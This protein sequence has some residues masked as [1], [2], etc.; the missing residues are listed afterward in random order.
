MHTSSQLSGAPD[1][2]STCMLLFSL[3]L[4]CI[5]FWYVAPSRNP[6]WLGHACLRPLYSSSGMSSSLSR[7]H[8]T[9]YYLPCMLEHA[10]VLTTLSPS[11][12]H[13]LAS[14]CILKIRDYQR[15]GMHTSLCIKL[16]TIGCNSKIAMSLNSSASASHACKGRKEIHSMVHALTP[17]SPRA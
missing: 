8:T 11:P 16:D 7:I 10:C 4:A 12:I 15:P 17:E 13:C 6:M 5:P 1:V 9:A 3:F 14:V 2:Y